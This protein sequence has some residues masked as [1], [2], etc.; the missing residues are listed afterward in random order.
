MNWLWLTLGVACL[1]ISCI[2]CYRS[3]YI[4]KTDRLHNCSCPMQV[5]SDCAPF[6]SLNTTC[7]CESL[8]RS[9]LRQKARTAR[10]NDNVFWSNRNSTTTVCCDGVA[11]DDAAAML[12]FLLDHIYVSNLTLH[13][14][15]NLILDG[16]V[17]LYGLESFY[18]YSD[19][20]SSYPRQELIMAKTDS[21]NWTRDYKDYHAIYVDMTIT[22]GA[23]PIKAWSIVRNNADN[24]SNILRRRGLRENKDGR[25]MIT[26]VYT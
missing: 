19:S 24:S 1:V 8:D 11:S 21:T 14:C 16:R 3:I 15:Q 12:D 6:A 17:I 13:R 5:S 23:S 2:R 9:E 25:F 7:A 20:G 22:K 18:V 10:R 4:L 26:Y